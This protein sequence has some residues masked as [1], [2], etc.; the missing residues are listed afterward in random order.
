MYAFDR[1]KIRFPFFLSGVHPFDGVFIRLAVFMGD[2][3]HNV[4]SICQ[5]HII[6]NI[7]YVCITFTDAGK[8]LAVQKNFRFPDIGIDGYGSDFLFAVHIPALRQVE[9]GVFTPV[10]LVP[11]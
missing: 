6:Y 1:K 11:K 4:L 3:L 7:M 8:F 5:G 2:G 10:R 9:D